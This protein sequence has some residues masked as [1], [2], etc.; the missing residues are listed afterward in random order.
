M[1]TS[2][3]LLA[4]RTDCE[5]DSPL[6]FDALLLGGYFSHVCLP[7]NCEY[8]GVG[9]NI[10][11]EG[12]EC[13]NEW[14]VTISNDGN[15]QLDGPSPMVLEVG[16]TYKFIIYTPG[17]PLYVESVSGAHLTDTVTRAPVVLTVE[18]DDPPALM[19]RSDTSEVV[20]YMSANVPTPVPTIEVR[21]GYEKGLRMGGAERG[22]ERE[23]RE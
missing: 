3:A 4:N 2:A 5:Y 20:A 6:N 16:R 14:R 22:L 13:D 10:A 18:A 23:R 7:T 19:V 9:T 8:G 12:F 15:I 21:L 11:W 17:I 1:D